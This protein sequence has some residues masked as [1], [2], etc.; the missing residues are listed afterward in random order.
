MERVFKNICITGAGNGIGRAIAIAM[1]KEGYNV[2]CADIDLNQ[3]NETLEIVLDNNGN[4]L[5]IEMDVTKSADIKNMIKDT[6]VKYGS[7]DI[8]VNNAGVTRTSKIMDLTEDDWDWI[9]NVNAKGT[10]FCL[11]AA[12]KQMIKQNN[13]GRIINM[14]SVGGKGFVDVSNAIYAASKGAVI[15][16][17]KTAAQELAKHE[18]TVNSICPGITYTNILS[19]IVK[20]RSLEQNKSEEDIMKHYVRDIPL[21]RPNYPEDIAAMVVFLSSSGARNITGQSYNVDGGLIPS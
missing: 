11:Q 4:G 7:L 15:S 20:K 3:A 2:V 8:L 1:G 5:S 14:A 10:F 16:L 9:H 21:Q 13:G 18:I 17:T 6:V 12:A 19:D